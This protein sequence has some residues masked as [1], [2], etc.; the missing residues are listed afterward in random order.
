M[1]YKLPLVDEFD[2][3]QTALAK[4]K[5][6]KILIALAQIRLKPKRILFF[7]KFG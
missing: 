3:R 6:N 4:L 2:K 1:L 5:K 7:L